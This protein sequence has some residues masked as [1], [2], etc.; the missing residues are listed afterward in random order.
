MDTNA[1]PKGHI[2]G[3]T[4]QPTVSKPAASSAASKSAKKNEKRKEKRKEK[5]EETK[6]KDNW[7]DDDDDE[8]GETQKAAD[9]KENKNAPLPDAKEKAQAGDASADS[10][11]VAEALADKLGKLEVR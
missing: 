5:R 2:I 8:G 1:L 6:V 3:W 4:P 7:E 11:D 10:G 9:N